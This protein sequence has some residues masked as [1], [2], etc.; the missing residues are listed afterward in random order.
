MFGNLKKELRAA[1]TAANEAR[2]ISTSV[3]ARL[4]QPPEPGEQVCLVE[5]LVI[6]LE[7]LGSTLRATIVSERAIIQ[8]Q[9]LTACSAGTCISSTSTARVAGRLHGK[10]ASSILLPKLTLSHSLKSSRGSYLPRVCRH[11]RAQRHRRSGGM[12]RL[13]CLMHSKL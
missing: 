6:R 12:P 8:I 7:K 4:P 11:Q 3:R 2:D 13:L 5:R 1:H 9:K 10:S